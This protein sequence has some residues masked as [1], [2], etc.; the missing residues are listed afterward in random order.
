MK[1]R[2]DELSKEE[3]QRAMD[4]LRKSIVVDGSV[5]PMLDNGYFER[6]RAGGITAA[7]VTVPG[8]NKNLSESIKEFGEH[9]IWLK[10]SGGQAFLATTVK[11]IQTAKTEGKCAIIFGPQNTLFIE[12]DPKLVDV[13][14]QLGVRIW[15]LTYQI[16]NLVGEGCGERTDGGLSKYGVKIL[17]KMNELGIVVDLSHCSFKTTME[18]IEFSKDPV[19]FS[20]TNPR[21]LCTSKHVRTKTDEEIKAMAEKGGVIGISSISMFCEKE[22][23]VRPTVEEMLDGLD[24]CVNLVGVDHVGIGVDVAERETA[25]EYALAMKLYPEFNR[26]SREEVRIIGMQ[27]VD[28]FPSIPKGLVARGYSD[29]E[30]EKILGGNF[31]RVF[32]KVWKK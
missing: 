17:E 10:E 6:M 30:I 28:Q 18:A 21:A 13:F 14:Y 32:K 9:Y 26:Y 27:T 15:Q 2:H 7:N 19:I 29:Q 5:V 22:Y 3:N 24:Y 12:N 31:L 25:E 20:H 11:D 16:R 8:V 23:D 1:K 4:I